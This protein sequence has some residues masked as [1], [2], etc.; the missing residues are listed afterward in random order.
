MGAHGH[1]FVESS[2]PTVKQIE[3]QYWVIREPGSGTRSRSLSS[4]HLE[5][6][7]NSRLNTE[8]PK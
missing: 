8:A 6:S 4:L 1:P 2:Q 5:S 7:P 3:E